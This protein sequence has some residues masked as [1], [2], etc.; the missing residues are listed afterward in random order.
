M[1][2]T[3]KDI[4]AALIVVVLDGEPLK[5]QYRCAAMQCAQQRNKYWDRRWDS[6]CI[7]KIWL[8][9][10]DKPECFTG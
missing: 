5:Q 1:H 6:V 2:T 8:S 10:L 9:Q 3:S 4:S 7:E